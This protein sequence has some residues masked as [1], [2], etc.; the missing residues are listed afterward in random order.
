MK[1]KDIRTRDDFK[2]Y[3]PA[4]IEVEQCDLD[5]VVDWFI[6]MEEAATLEDYNRKDIANLLLG[7]FAGINNDP[8][9]AHKSYFATVFE[10]A[11]YYNDD[12]PITQGDLRLSDMMRSEAV[13]VLERNLTRHFGEGISW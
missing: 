3:L 7:G 4:H 13:K 8:D 1:L 6:A 12:Y 5:Q 10:N 9:G 11:D 2:A